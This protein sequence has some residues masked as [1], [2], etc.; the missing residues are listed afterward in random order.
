MGHPP[1]AQARDLDITLC[2]FLTSSPRPSSVVSTSSLRDLTTSHIHPFM[3]GPEQDFLR[4][5]PCPPRT[6]ATRGVTLR[7]FPP[8]SPPWRRLDPHFLLPHQVVSPPKGR[9]GC[10]AENCVPKAWDSA[11]HTPGFLTEEQASERRFVV[12]PSSHI[13]NKSIRQNAHHTILDE[14]KAYKTGSVA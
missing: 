8:R 6:P 7:P 9:A 5:T 14:E 2:S 3:A 10:L 1:G 13:L 11:W 12:Q 4:A